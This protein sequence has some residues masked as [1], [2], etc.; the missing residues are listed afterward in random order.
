MNE[1]QTP[2]PAG[3]GGPDG[4]YPPGG[5]YPGPFEQPAYETPPPVPTKT[6]QEAPKKKMRR[7]GTFTM[8]ICLIAIGTLL[9]L[10]V[11]LPGLDYLTI[12]RFS[13]L[14]LVLLGLEIL[15]A[16]IRN[17]DGGLRYDWLGVLICILLIGGTLLTAAV[18]AVF[19]QG[20]Q[21]YR[22]SERLAAELEDQTVQKLRT[23][24]GF[25]AARAEWHVSPSPDDFRTDMA[26]SDIPATQYV[27]M[28]LYLNDEFEDAQAFV[29]ACHTAAE[30]IARIAPHVDNAV[31][32]SGAQGMDVYTGEESYWLET[33]NRYDF[34]LGLDQLAA[35]V[36][37]EHW[38]TG[39]GVYAP[40][41][42]DSLV[43]T[44][45]DEMDETYAYP[46]DWEDTEEWEAREG[47]EMPDEDGYRAA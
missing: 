34:E 38:Q 28:S 6:E 39:D 47:R 15:V 10:Y 27:H 12:L 43:D 37:T 16:N 18:P 29:K 9:V 13:P 35:R 7:V 2:L 40:H 21:A 42:P 22:T 25:E 45:P 5:S 1:Q 24:P 36:H 3:A 20:V 33:T 46:E 41:M 32:Y 44:L 14:V 31:F 19:Q 23:L 17:K 8:A 4:F 26:I 11:V 30:E